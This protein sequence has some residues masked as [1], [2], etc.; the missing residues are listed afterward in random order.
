MSQI[1]TCRLRTGKNKNAPLLAWKK[2]IR[3]RVKPTGSKQKGPVKTF[4]ISNLSKF[5]VKNKRHIWKKTYQNTDTIDKKKPK[6]P[7]ISVVGSELKNKKYRS[8]KLSQNKY[9]PKNMQMK[10]FTSH[11]Q[12][13]SAKKIRGLKSAFE[14][15]ARSSKKV[16]IGKKLN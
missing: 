12:L 10:K 15:K 16:R 14:I 3:L 9:K 13:A 1:K 6:N 11:R 8:V 7:L 5:N 4:K 2:T